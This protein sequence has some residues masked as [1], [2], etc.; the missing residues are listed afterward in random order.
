MTCVLGNKAMKNVLKSVTSF[1]SR[2]RL[3]A[4]VM[5]VA[6]FLSLA[7]CSTLAEEEGRLPDAM[8]SAMTTLTARGYPDLTKIPD[9]PK[10]VP[11]ASTWSALEAGLVS[12]GQRVSASPLATPLTAEETNLAW[13][14]RD[15][16][17]LVTDP[18]AQPLPPV[19][20]GSQTEAE[21]AAQAKAKLDAD[22]ARLPPP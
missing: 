20:P 17:T 9:A 19:V 22:I 11:P 5:I 12:Q 3:A 16:A 8:R 14:D 4:G 18:R 7:A 13:A 1:P 21:W 15:R 2:P 6:G 10:D